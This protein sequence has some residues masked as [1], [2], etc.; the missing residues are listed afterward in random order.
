MNLVVNGVRFHM[1]EQGSGPLTLVF[2]HYFGGSALEW[3]VVMN[4]LSVQYR[5]LAIDLRGCGDS[6]A[7]ATGYSVD[8]MADDVI[9]LIRQCAISEF[10]LIGH[11][12]S[13]K[14]ALA[15][16][17][18][19]PAQG[20]PIG[21]QA[22]LLVSPSPPVPEPIPDDE[23]QLLLT[24]HGHRA[25]AEKMAKNTTAI[26][27]SK[28]VRNQIVADDL[29]TS[30]AAWM[31]WLTSGS[32]ENISARMPAI[33]I[34]V[35]IVVGSEDRALPPDVQ[36]QLVL[37]YLKRVTLEIIAG[38]GHLLPW[39]TPVELAAFITKKIAG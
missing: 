39:E 3:Q 28:A 21:L 19:T 35:H 13:G 27:V 30:P 14:V 16:A 11:S 33:Q 6:E 7:P 26:Q 23:R 1:L 4:R 37:P 10:V 18:G 31:A 36:H 25:A 29:R 8:D 12:M 9:C 24:N 32:R 17:A 22:L 2:L 15:I 20:R 38:A 5:C 34:P